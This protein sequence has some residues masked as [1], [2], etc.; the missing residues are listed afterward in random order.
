LIDFG[1]AAAGEEVREDID[2]WRSLQPDNPSRWDA[3]R[4]LLFEALWAA[5]QERKQ[6]SRQK[7]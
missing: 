2:Y 1:L 6:A 4:C 5:E 7:E 3:I